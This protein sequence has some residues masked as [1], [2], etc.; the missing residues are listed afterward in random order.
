M[1]TINYVLSVFWKEVQ[2]MLKDVGALALFF[3]LPLLMSS[4]IGGINVM[5]QQQ[6]AT[7]ILLRVALVNADNGAFGSEI[8]KALGEIEELEITPYATAGAAEEQVAQGK[9]TAAVIIPA[10]F[11]DHINAHEPV[12]I[13]IIVDPGE[14]QSAGIVTGI[15]NHVVAEVTIWGEVQYGVRSLLEESGVLQ[16]LAPAEQQAVG[17]QTLGAIMTVLNE[18]RRTP[19]IAV[20]SESQE[21]AGDLDWLPLFLAL[22]FAGFTVMFIF[23]NTSWSSGALLAERETGT[24]RRLLAAPIPRG[25]VIVGKMLAFVALSC[26]QVVVMFSVASIFFDVPLGESPLALV[27]VTL[28]VAIAST[29]MGMLIAALSKSSDKAGNTGV[30]AGLVLS[31]IGGCMGVR[32]PLTRTE[33]FAGI[34][35]RLTPQGHAVTAFYSV[36]AEKATLVQVLPQIGIL[37]A[38]ATVFYAIAVWRFKFEA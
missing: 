16:T 6:D 38:M 20:A 28:S 33:G 1:K 21:T 3:L 30:I 36:M 18:M 5:T 9:V 22:T 13:D 17:A 14:P 10:Q 26:M 2:L 8:A 4:L 19:A 24:L 31:A 29:S 11:S 35:A 15:M 27:C 37:L 34:L 12:A 7:V 25:A 23:I 32:V